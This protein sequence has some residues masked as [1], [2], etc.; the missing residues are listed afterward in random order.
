LMSSQ[1]VARQFEDLDMLSAAVVSEDGVLLG[2]ITE[3]DV[4]DSIR[5]DS[6][7]AIMGMA[8]LDDEADMFAPILTSTRRRSVWLG[9]NLITAFLPAS[10]I[11]QFQGALSNIVSLAV[12][13]PVVAIMGGIAASPPLPLVLCGLG[14]G[15]VDT[16]N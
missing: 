2:R 4:M 8:G 13:M 15:Q 11:G 3:D 6:E 14:F 1:E 12:L 5:D 9:C 10:V 16:G 7:R